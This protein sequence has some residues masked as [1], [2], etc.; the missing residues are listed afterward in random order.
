MSGKHR[1][2]N[3]PASTARWSSTLGWINHAV[4]NV[5]CIVPPVI[6]KGNGFPTG[7]KENEGHDENYDL[8]TSIESSTK[9]VV[10]FQEPL[11]LVSAKPELAPESDREE[12]HN[13]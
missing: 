13:H 2:S 6:W 8:C 4:V 10:E 9:D 11:G 5:P 7:T 12:G 1:T 3:A